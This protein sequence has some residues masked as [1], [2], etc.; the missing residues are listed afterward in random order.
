MRFRYIATKKKT[1]PFSLLGTRLIQT[2]KLSKFMLMKCMGKIQLHS[3]CTFEH[4][5]HTN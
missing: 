3:K 1:H 5:V 2:S 4:G